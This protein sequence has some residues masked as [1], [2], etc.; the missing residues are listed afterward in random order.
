MD[1]RVLSLVRGGVNRCL[2]ASEIVDGIADARFGVHR[3]DQMFT[4]SLRAHGD[5]GAALTQYFNVGLQ[6]F[7][8]FDFVRRVWC[9]EASSR[10]VLDFACGFGRCLRFAAAIRSN[11]TIWGSEIQ[12]DALSFIHHEF[13]VATLQSHADPAQFN[14]D[15]RFDLIWVAS[16][17]THLPQTLF[18]EWLRKLTSLLS[19]AGLLCF[20]ARDEALLVGQKR[21]GDDGFLYE[22]E[23]ENAQLPSDIYG[24]TYVNESYVSN[25]LHRAAGKHASYVRIPRLLAMEQDLYCVSPTHRDL[26]ALTAMPQGCWGWLDVRTVSR[27]GFIHLEGWA[28][29]MPNRPA[30]FVEIFI[31]NERFVAIPQI[32]R[33]D[34]ADAFAD[35]GLL[36]SGWRFEQQLRSPTRDVPLIILAHAKDRASAALV[37]AGILYPT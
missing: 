5:Q 30:D 27:D 7:R 33:P 22:S 12:A 17:F 3:D 9:N 34:V 28:A 13:S 32:E 19:P 36:R 2:S 35:A 6:Q 21:L 15:E 26:G 10:R 31:N 14:P 18:F 29:L 4:H 25:C 23:S 8:C 37:Y 1:Q 11:V 24:T 20:S 16:L